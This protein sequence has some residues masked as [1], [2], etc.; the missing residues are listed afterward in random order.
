M[1]SPQHYTIKESYRNQDY[2]A[3]IRFDQATKLW[4]WKSTIDFD[5]GP[6]SLFTKRTFIT[7]AQAEE[8]MRQSTHQC[9]DNRLG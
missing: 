3:V 2:T 8:H 9:I 6:H 7:A 4:R 1:M 5:A